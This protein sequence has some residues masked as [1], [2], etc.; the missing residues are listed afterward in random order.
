M[1]FVEEWFD[2]I[3]PYD[4]RAIA[5]DTVDM[6]EFCEFYQMNWG[7]FNDVIFNFYKRSKD[8]VK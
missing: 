1:K 6:A 2:D 3:D 8:V 7:K 5:W 4:M